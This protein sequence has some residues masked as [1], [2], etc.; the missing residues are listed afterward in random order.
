[1]AH[2]PL[3]VATGFTREARIVAQPGVTA[4][5]GG[6]IAATLERL[7]EEQAP[8]ACAIASF[9][10]TGALADGLRIGDWIIGDRLAG[11]V[12]TE[13]DRAWRDAVIRR[14]PDARVGAFYADGSMIASVEAKRALGR[15]HRALAVDMESHIA[16]RVAARHGLPFMVVRIVSDGVDHMLP[17]AITVSMKPGGAID[18]AAMLGSLLRQPG[19]LPVFTSTIIGAAKAFRGLARGHAAIGPR[20]AFPD[21]G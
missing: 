17:P 10:L 19:Q 2:K 16:A 21:L 4:I 3:L 7:L 8:N 14:L 1:V 9:G 6:G 12:E 20:L 18:T 15:D 13:T 5:P 11:A